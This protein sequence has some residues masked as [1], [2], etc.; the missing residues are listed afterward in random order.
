YADNALFTLDCQTMRLI[1]ITPVK[2][3]EKASKL[4]FYSRVE[5]ISTSWWVWGKA[6]H[7]LEAYTP[8]YLKLLVKYNRGSKPLYDYINK[9]DTPEQALIK[10]FTIKE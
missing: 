6:S 3:E 7:P 2:L 8:H 1:Q 10:K 4:P 9:L 5:T